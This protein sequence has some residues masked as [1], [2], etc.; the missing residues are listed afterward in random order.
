[1]ET[2]AITFA[3]LPAEAAP[4][5]QARIEARPPGEFAKILQAQPAQAEKPDGEIPDGQ[6]GEPPATAGQ[7]IPFLVFSPLPALSPGGQRLSGESGL[8]TAASGPPDFGNHRPAEVA[9][10]MI[11]DSG[12]ISD[13]AAAVLQEGIGENPS[14]PAEKSF[15]PAISPNEN[16]LQGASVL[17]NLSPGK[18]AADSFPEEKMRLHLADSKSRQTPEGGEALLKNLKNPTSGDSTMIASEISARTKDPFLTEPKLSEF[19]LP[20]NSKRGDPLGNP[21]SPVESSAGLRSSAGARSENAPAL[22]QPSK[23]G[24]P[25]Q[26]SQ[27]MVWSLGRHEERFRLTL[28]PPHLGSIYLE[29]QRDKEQV[30]AT[31]WAENPNTKQILESN[32]FSI[33]KIIETEGFSLE[34]FNVFVEQDL[35]AFQESRERMPNPSETATSGSKDEVKGELSVE[36]SAPGRFAQKGGGGLRSI[37]LIV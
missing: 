28:D 6:E 2:T 35:S 32:Q 27:K 21:S 19:S 30:R 29:I 25:E 31:M 9:A 18:E 13:P 7:E 12:A 16:A 22:S 20:E 26:I 1:M 5:T 10:V 3:S 37:N 33:Q 17:E 36:P 34:S 15:R 24:V 11:P 4:A 8:G 14:S 23:A